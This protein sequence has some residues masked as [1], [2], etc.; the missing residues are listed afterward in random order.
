MKLL[1][2]II[3]SFL[4]FSF[5][6]SIN[7]QPSNPG[8]GMGEEGICYPV[9]IT[10][11][12]AT[13]RIIKIEYDSLSGNAIRMV[14]TYDDGFT[15][16]KLF[17]RT[18]AGRYKITDYNSGNEY[19]STKFISLGGGGVWRSTYSINGDFQN[20]IDSSRVEFGEVSFRKDTILMSGVFH[21]IANDG[22]TT[23]NEILVRLDENG[24]HKTREIYNN[25]ELTMIVFYDQYESRFNPVSFMESL[26]L[27]YLPM[28]IF[29][30]QTIITYLEGKPQEKKVYRY[31][32]DYDKDLLP[33][34]IERKLGDETVETW[35]II[36][37]CQK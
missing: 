14:T 32:I 33:K 35:D 13:N 30:K 9:L 27:N 26:T 5:N 8:S 12:G 1:K 22:D 10:Y 18:R 23:R 24:N 16:A 34:H 2:I 15:Y 28:N 4:L 25:S 37:D 29:R 17:D 7:A 19:K 3:T 21:D 36:Y 31:E 6:S 11:R 20:G